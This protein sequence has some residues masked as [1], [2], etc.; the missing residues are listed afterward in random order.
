MPC[1][2]LGLGLGGDGFRVRIWWSWSSSWLLSLFLKWKY[3]REKE[4]EESWGDLAMIVFIF[5]RQKKYI[6]MEIRQK[7]HRGLYN[8]VC[9]VFGA[10]V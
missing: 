4:K 6:Y 10:R 5:F 2:C 7:A 9:C 1:L 8:C 3:L